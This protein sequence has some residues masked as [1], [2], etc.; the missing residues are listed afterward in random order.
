MV[1]VEM[2]PGGSRVAAPAG[3]WPPGASQQ[4][5][6]TEH[7]TQLGLP[8]ARSSAALDLR[9]LDTRAPRYQIRPAIRTP[10]WK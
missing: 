10:A 3:A 7:A 2:D 5:D 4:Q 1:R 6:D 9:K 8:R